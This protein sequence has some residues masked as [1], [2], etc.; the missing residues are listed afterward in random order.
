L[1]TQFVVDSRQADTEALNLHNYKNYAINHICVV[2]KQACLVFKSLNA[3]NG[4]N[5]IHLGSDTTVERNM[6]NLNTETYCRL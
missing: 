4:T 3:L 6:T 2:S 1:K 5:P